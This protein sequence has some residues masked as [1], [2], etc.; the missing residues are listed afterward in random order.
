MPGCTLSVAVCVLPKVAVSGQAQQRPRARPP[1]RR[2]ESFAAAR[3]GRP[4]RDM[5]RSC[6]LMGG[7][8]PRSEPTVTAAGPAIWLA[9]AGRCWLPLGTSGVV[10]CQ[11]IVRPQPQPLC[12]C[13][14][15]CRR[16]HPSFVPMPA[17]STMCSLP[18][19]RLYLLHILSSFLLLCACSVQ[20][21]FFSSLPSS[22]LPALPTTL[23]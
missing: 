18:A 1:H 22:F 21:P 17:M 12:L 7:R 10:P 15:C 23:D 5:R 19:L 16:Q 3:P 9:P 20:G 11:T 8:D 14:H 6:S 13:L 2:P 4:V